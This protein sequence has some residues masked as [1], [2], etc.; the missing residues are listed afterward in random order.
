M[1][2]TKT[3]LIDLIL[4]HQWPAVINH[5]KAFSSDAKVSWAVNQKSLLPLHLACQNG[6]PISVIKTLLSAHPAAAKTKSE[7]NGLLPL[8][9]LF[10][11]I[12]ASSNNSATAIAT[13]F[14]PPNETTVSALL[15]AYPTAARVPD[16]NGKLPLHHACQSIGIT[17]EVFTALL[18]TH[19]EGAYA[20]DFEGN[21]PINYATSNT[22]TT[23]KQCA[24]AALDRSTLYAFI[25]KMTSIRLVA[26]HDAKARALEES[27]AKKINAM[28]LHSKQERLKWA[29]LMEDLKGEHR[30]EKAKNDVL[31]KENQE[32]VRAKDEA[33]AN[34]IRGEQVQHSKLESELRSNLAEVQLKNMDLLEELETATEDLTESKTKEIALM[35]EIASLEQTLAGATTSL[36]ET[37]KLLHSKQIVLRTTQ[38]EVTS[39]EHTCGKQSQRI[40]HLEECLTS[41]HL[42]IGN[43]AKDMKARG[44]IL[45]NLL[46]GQDGSVKDVDCLLVEMAGCLANDDCNDISNG[47]VETKEKLI[48]ANEEDLVGATVLSNMNEEG[49]VLQ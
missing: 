3:A 15:E 6:A 28:E 41:A 4:Q 14:V 33:V 8:H 44:D 20:R 43:M 22:Y 11:V 32:L 37:K 46:A 27:H 34:A 42:S 30:M 45:R 29:S 38:E 35:E 19:P 7:P 16:R 25:S 2:S 31:M 24:L 21:F 12:I 40:S 39:L 9:C 18:S 23:T 49:G 5:L 17:E 36:E 48:T 26:E 1:N 13:S 10:I 47:V